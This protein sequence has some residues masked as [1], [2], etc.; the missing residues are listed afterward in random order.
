MIGKLSYKLGGEGEK[1]IVML[2]GWG[3]SSKS[4]ELVEQEFKTKAK[5]LV[6]D[7]Y[8]FGNS[9][10]PPNY[11]DTYEYAYQ[12]FLLLSQLGC[13]KIVLIGHSFGGRVA[14]I[15]S[16]VF[17]LDICGL[18]LTASAGLNRFS[19]LREARVLK[20]K[21]LKKLSQRGLVKKENLKKYGSSD[22]KKL[23]NDMK[24]V[25]RNVVRQDLSHLLVKICVP[26]RLYWARDDKETPFWICKKLHKFIKYSQIKVCKNGGHFVYIKRCHGFIKEIE[27]MI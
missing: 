25:F 17:N 20:Y 19:V 6:V 13:N 15:L 1:T 16:S 21:I 4:F 26:T 2:H 3:M 9:D 18:V 22:Y 27:K 10:M 23:D 7:F 14:I 24:S 11:F 12:L 8:G 5:C